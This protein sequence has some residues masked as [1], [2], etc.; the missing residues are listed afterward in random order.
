MSKKNQKLSRNETVTKA[1]WSKTSLTMQK[2]LTG[3]IDSDDKGEISLSEEKGKA[4]RTLDK[5][6]WWHVWERWSGRQVAD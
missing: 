5:S 3:S 6:M 4:L 1:L 2:S